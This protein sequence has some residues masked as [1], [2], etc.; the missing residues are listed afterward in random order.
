MLLERNNA[1]YQLNKAKASGD[2]EKGDTSVNMALR[3][4]WQRRT[5]VADAG[6]QQIY[7]KSAV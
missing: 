3:K 1:G 2:E 7:Q 6:G 5:L 4:L